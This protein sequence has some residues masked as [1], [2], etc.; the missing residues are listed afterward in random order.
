MLDVGT[1]LGPY[2]VIARLGEGGMGEVEGRATDAR[3]DVFA[4]GAV[5]YEMVTGKRAFDG[6]FGERDGCDPAKRAST[7]IGVTTN[8]PA[9]ARG[10]RQELPREGSRRAV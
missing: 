7:A 2:E 10:D 4:F 5:L 6:R 8:D 1:H 3:T 9:G